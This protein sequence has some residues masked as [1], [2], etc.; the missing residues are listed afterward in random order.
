MKGL[1]HRMIRTLL[2]LL[3]IQ[4]V[5]SQQ[6]SQGYKQIYIREDDWETIEEV[7]SKSLCT[8]RTVLQGCKL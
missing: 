5:A 1:N 2:A 3:T 8:V 6:V 4:Y 7:N